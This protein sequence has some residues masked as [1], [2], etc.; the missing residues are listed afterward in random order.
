MS[1][2]LKHAPAAG[3]ALVLVIEQEHPGVS[4]CSGSTAEAP[5]KKIKAESRHREIARFV[6]K[7]RLSIFSK[8]AGVN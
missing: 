3:R 4:A 6:S 7:G 1:L 8:L 2:Y 5:Q